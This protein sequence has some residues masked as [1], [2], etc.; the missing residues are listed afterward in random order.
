MR[1]LDD[2]AGGETVG[3]RLELQHF[4]L[5]QDRVEQRSMPSPVLAD[6]GTNMLSPPHSSAM[7]SC[8]RQLG[9]HAIR[10]GVG[11]VDL[12]DRHDNG[13]ARRLGVLD[14]FDG[15]R[16]DAVVGR[17]H[18]HHDVGEPWRRARASR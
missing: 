7:T 18:Q 12:V 11:L 3:R 16:H 5:Q 10:I 13:N 2:D 15:L 4:G 6:T 8:L 14:G 9:A 17:D 1:R